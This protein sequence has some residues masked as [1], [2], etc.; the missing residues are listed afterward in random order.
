MVIRIAKNEN[1]S[2]AAS[3]IYA[4]SWKSGYKGVFSDELLNDISL[5]RWVNA[6]NSNYETHR[7]QIAIMNV[8]GEDIGAGGYGL[9]RDYDNPKIGE[10][11]SI[12]FIDTAWGRGYSKILMNFMID[13]LRS[14]GCDKVHLW[15]VKDNIRAQR[16]YEKYG[17]I[18]T[19]KEKIITFKGE[20]VI[21]IEYEIEEI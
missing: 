20:S 1:D 10:V 8:D 16:F 4:L 15:V 21:D 9:S 18:P 12:Y 7:F 14:K 19:G 6:F 5:E 2:I 11:T 13:E 3:R 17:F